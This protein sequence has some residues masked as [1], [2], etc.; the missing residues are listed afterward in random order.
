ML[1]CSFLVLE[2]KECEG[3]LIE[4][5]KHHQVGERLVYIYVIILISLFFV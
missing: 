1:D 4:I 2:F 3:W 5:V